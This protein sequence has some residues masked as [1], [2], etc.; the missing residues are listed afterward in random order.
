MQVEFRKDF[1]VIVPVELMF[2]WYRWNFGDYFLIS[3]QVKLRLNGAG[4]ISE[5]GF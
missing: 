4:G 2:D 1:S 5:T 3:V